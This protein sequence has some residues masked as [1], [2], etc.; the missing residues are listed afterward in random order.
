[1]F[2]VI[3]ESCDVTPLE[4]VYDDL[5]IQKMEHSFDMDVTHG[6]KKRKYALTIYKITKG[7]EVKSMT[8]K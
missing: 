7:N 6:D 5:V 1:M 8:F 2:I 4:G 3:P